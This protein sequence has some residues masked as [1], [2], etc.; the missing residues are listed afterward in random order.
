MG[1]PDSRTSNS[2]R[3]VCDECH[4]SVSWIQYDFVGPE[5]VQ[6]LAPCGHHASLTFK[7]A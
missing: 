7:A 5:P 4:E 2:L 6:F 1:N 3:P